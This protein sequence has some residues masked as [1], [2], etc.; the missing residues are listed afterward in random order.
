MIHNFDSDIAKEYGILEAILLNHIYYWIEKNRANEQ[1]FFDGKYWTYN[2]TKAFAELFPYAS[3]K[4]IKN[5]LKHLREEEILLA[6]NYNE[7]A[8]DRT[9]WYSIS[10]YGICLIEKRQIDNPKSD[11]REDCEGKSIGP[12]GT[13]EKTNEDNGLD[14]EVRPIPNNKPDIKPNNNQECI[15][16]SDDTVCRT[17][18]QRVVTAWNTLGVNPVS[19]VLPKSTR[20]KMIVARIAEYGID[21]VLK[22]VEKVRGST[23]LRGGSQRG[24]MITF[25]WFAR[26]NNFPKVLEGQYDDNKGGCYKNDLEEW[27]ND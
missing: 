20:Y 11:N 17:D 23:F 10:E 8:Y 16:V 19:R 12:V 25:E 15:T 27:S 22:A 21:D 7:N 1:N 18:V 9:L 3:E 5:A 24:W 2:S 13:M 14:C 4:Q 6:G 26:P